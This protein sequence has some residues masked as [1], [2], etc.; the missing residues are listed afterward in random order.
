M[1][2]KFIKTGF[3]VTSSLPQVIQSRPYLALNQSVSHLLPDDG[4]PG[5]KLALY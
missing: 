2:K 4:H 3:F 5:T 1:F